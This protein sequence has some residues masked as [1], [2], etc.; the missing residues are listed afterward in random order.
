MR[1]YVVM[2]IDELGDE[3]RPD[4][5]SDLV[6]E[7]PDFDEENEPMWSAFLAWEASCLDIVH[8]RIKERFGEGWECHT[9]LDRSDYGRFN[10]DIW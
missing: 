9:F 6:F 1:T 3:F 10:F 4:F 7:F 5:L 8:E 2:A